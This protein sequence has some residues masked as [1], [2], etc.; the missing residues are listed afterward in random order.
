MLIPEQTAQD[1]LE[2]EEKTRRNSGTKIWLL[3]CGI[4]WLVT[5]GVFIWVGKLADHNQVLHLRT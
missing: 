2:F 5:I 1:F 3:L 4:L